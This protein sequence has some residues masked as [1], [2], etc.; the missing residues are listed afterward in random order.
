[1]AFD[2]GL[3]MAIPYHACYGAVHM[4]T[5]RRK[6][7]PRD[8]TSDAWEAIG[9]ALADMMRAF[10][11]VRHAVMAGFT[12]SM[13]RDPGAVDDLE[14]EAAARRWTGSLRLLAESIGHPPVL[15]EEQALRAGKAAGKAR[16]AAKRRAKGK[17]KR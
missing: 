10:P 12:R 9:S 11:S 13:G 15:N 16:A 2:M 3:G 7:P 17:A 4:T 1:M 5:R 8:S 6:A 14:R